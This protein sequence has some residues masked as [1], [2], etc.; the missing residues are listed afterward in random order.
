MK[1]Q[2]HYGT[3]GLERDASSAEIK[4]AY[5]KLAHRFHP[6]VSN[7]PDGECQFKNVSAAYKTL[8]CVETRAAYDLQVL[9]G[10]DVGVQSPAS[11][12]VNT[13]CALNPWREWVWFCA[14]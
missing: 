9:P 10:H 6:D 14:N 11:D 7:D 1:T 3:L 5:R 4:L 13:W 8:N 2:N 12:A